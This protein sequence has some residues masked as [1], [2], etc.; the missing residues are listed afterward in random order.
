MDTLS[1][2]NLSYDEALFKRAS[3]F[4]RLKNFSYE[5]HYGKSYLLNGCI[6]QG[7]WSAC[8]IIG[9]AIKQEKGIIEKNGEPFEIEARKSMSWFVRK[10]EIKRFGLFR[11][12]L[13]AQIQ[14]GLR[15]IPN[16][17]MQSEE[18]VIRHFRLT[19]ERFNPPMRQFS[20]EG[21]RA[22]C[23]I[24]FV[25]GKSIYCF[26]HIGYGSTHLITDYREWFEELLNLLKSSGA[27]V[28]VPIHMAKQA[29]GLCDEVVNFG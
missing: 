26:P 15:T 18:D 16:Q 11:Q 24:G 2:K 10:S 28:L 19:P 17:R 7:A 29:E 1:V 6:G 23:A 22:S 27:L 3:L 4:D 5:F 8:W 9:G 25:N 21:W 13:K 14:H 12:S 20:G